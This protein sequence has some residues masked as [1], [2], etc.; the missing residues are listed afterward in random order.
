MIKKQS[1]QNRPVIYGSKIFAIFG[2]L[3]FVLIS[4]EGWAAD[5][6]GSKDHPLIK[7]FGGSEIVGY[8]TKRFDEY[9]LQTATFKTY[10]LEAKK[11]E[12][13]SPGLKLEG[14]VTRIWYEAPGDAGSA[15]LSGN[16]RNEL[17]AQGF[18]IL[19]DSTKDAAATKWTGFL[20]AFGNRKVATS[21]SNYIFMAADQQGIRVLSAKKE[22]AEGDIYVYLTTV[23]WAKDD[24]VYKAKKGACAAVDIIEVRPMQQNM[25]VVKAE[26][27]AKEIT[28]KGRVALYGI[29]F[30]V[31]Q[32]T[33]KPESMAAIQEIATL[34]KQDPNLALHVVGHTDNAG[35][36]E[37][38]LDLSKRRAESVKT[39]LVRDYGIAE[40][41]LTPNGVAYLAPV[42]TNATEEGR[43]KNRRV[44]LVPR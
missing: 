32:A 44:E 16:Y 35:G 20:N 9:E 34:L 39:I 17:A 5:L 37:H 41:R 27:M 42:A 6:Q 29:L 12:F 1:A 19:Y 4:M 18:T 8:D 11:R 15:E 7:R 3:V 28:L 26:E 38:N 25:V 2:I 43:A 24:V 33:V 23:E 22:R 40:K 21:R 14:S 31:D 36:F 10:N 30:D 13:V